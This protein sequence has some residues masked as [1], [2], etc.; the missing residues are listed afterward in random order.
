MA[1][2]LRDNSGVK[3]AIQ[4]E[5]IPNV[6]AIAKKYHH[7]LQFNSNLLHML[8]IVLNQH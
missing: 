6:R 3:S 5:N 7:P 4:V 8:K 1:D 2:M